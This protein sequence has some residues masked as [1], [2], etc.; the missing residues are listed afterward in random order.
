M[1]GVHLHDPKQDYGELHRTHEQV[2][3]QLKQNPLS[4]EQLQEMEQRYADVRTAGKLEPTRTEIGERAKM[5][6]MQGQLTKQLESDHGQD[7]DAPQQ[8]QERALLDH[9]HLAEKVGFEARWI[10]QHLR[11]QGTPEESY[12]SEARSIHQ[13]ARQVHEQRQNLGASVDRGQE[14]ARVV[15]QQDQQKRDDAQQ[16]AVGNISLTSEQRANAAAD[17]KQ[18]L[19]RKDQPDASRTGSAEA[20]NAGAQEGKVKPSNARPGGRPR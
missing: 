14:H 15:R 18:P 10:A 4:K 16:A 2:A 11:K 8:K 12:E 17:I 9:Q 20:V 13:T 7:P 19:D 1:Q 6:A 3:A 5:I